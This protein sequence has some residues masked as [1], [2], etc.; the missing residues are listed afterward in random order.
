MIPS[1]LESPLSTITTP[2]VMTST[3]TGC[4]LYDLSHVL[5]EGS[6]E[7]DIEGQF[8][9]PPPLSDFAVE[10][11]S[12]TQHINELSNSSFTP[13][14]GLNN[15]DH[16]ATKYRSK[17]MNGLDQF[18]KEMD[19]KLY[20]AETRK[21][22]V[23]YQSKI[24]DELD[25]RRW[26]SSDDDVEY[27]LLV[28]RQK[29]MFPFDDED[30]DWKE[31]MFIIESL[32][33]EMK[34][35]V[36][37]EE[38]INI[39]EKIL[40]ELDRC[41]RNAHRIEEGE[42]L[43]DLREKFHSSELGSHCFLYPR[44]NTDIAEDECRGNGNNDENNEENNNENNDGDDDGNAKSNDITKN[45]DLHDCNGHENIN[46]DTG[47]RKRGR[48]GQSNF[49]TE[50][51]GEIGHPFLNW[52]MDQAQ[53]E[54]FMPSYAEQEGFAVNPHKEHR[55]TVVRW[56]CVHAGKYN[57]FRGLP[58]EVTEKNR[59]QETIETG[60]HQVYKSTDK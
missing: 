24:L 33:Q 7:C 46:E 31:M 9:F 35:S 17:G 12:A 32:N 38:K 23:D 5:R 3:M 55:G 1:T 45:T 60:L 39:K 15:H 34:E 47:N 43:H 13:V 57:N 30:A 56:R 10:P 26:S 21:E 37:V 19:R 16:H 58:A 50:S 59:H 42:R 11:A 25:S 27:E 28:L 48:K 2:M 53:M 14:H 18:L 41:L 22:A 29:Y 40:E 36:T 6:I 49:S 52:E 44:F 54:L 4:L 51:L 8:K 20:G